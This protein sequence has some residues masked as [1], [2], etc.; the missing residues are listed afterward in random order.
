MTR[1]FID[2]ETHSLTDLRKLGSSA[3]AQDPST[4]VTC[5]A[6]AIDDTP[7]QIW[8]PGM[9]LPDDMVAVVRAGCEVHAWNSK[10]ER[11]IW[12]NIMVP[13]RSAPEI[14][15]EQWH[16]TMARANYWGLPAKLELAGAALGLPANQQKVSARQLML[17]LA[18]PRSI[19]VNGQPVWWHETDKAKL[20][21]LMHYC[22]GDVEAERAIHKR[23][24]DLP[25]R[26]RTLWL[27]DQD[28]NHR[29]IAVD[30]E[31]TSKMRGIATAAKLDIDREL[32]DLT[33]GT[34]TGI[35]QQAK[36]LD[37][38]RSHGMPGLDDLKK[39][40]IEPLADPYGDVAEQALALRRDGARTSTA[41][42]N[43]ML[44]ALEPDNRLRGSL[45]YY[46][47]R[48]GRWSGTGGAKVQLHNLPRGTLKDPLTACQDVLDDMPIDFLNKFHGRTLDVVS[49]CLRGCFVAAPGKHL[50]VSDLSQIEA[51]LLA[52]LAGQR[53]VLDVFA[54]GQDIY[55]YDA[56]KLGSNNRQ[57]GKTFRL[58][59]GYGT[60]V[61]KII[62]IAKGYG[63]VLSVAKAQ[64]LIYQWRDD[65]RAITGLWNEL[66][67]A[68]RLAINCPP[69]AAVYINQWLKIAR[70]TGGLAI[71]LPSGRWL[72]YRNARWVEDPDT[73]ED[74]MVYDGVDRYT[75][76]WGPIR[77]W[78]SK[79]AADVTQAAARDVMADN[80]LFLDHMSV[81]LILSVH[82]E[83]IAEVDIN[84]S[85]KTLYLML[86]T[87]RTEPGWAPGLPVWAEGWRGPRYH[88]A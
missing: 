84:Q 65:N 61:A 76:Q 81:D 22:L 48:T 29:G 46:G 5:M 88:K 24:S 1:L 12:D 49:S 45:R 35:N 53:D 87:M 42:L 6:W 44:G 4:D 72:I 69:G 58:G 11:D 9:W 39:D 27:L 13:R 70:T 80:M 51:R 43:A 2:F 34:V 60:G 32:S 37:F 10:F 57:L 8:V 66:E 78:G 14:K 64:Q 30:R 68:F 7:P 50:V 33:G 77:V 85:D 67:A 40:T 82:D 52:W 17:Q 16:C 28:M 36:L 26:E 15:P 20:M 25:P 71:V 41:K 47:T 59:A 86:D 63:V 19:D 18:R 83:L 62:A 23:T 73:G 55:T 79:L 56:H 31:F 21:D 75:N 74:Q 3:Y 38:V 54:S